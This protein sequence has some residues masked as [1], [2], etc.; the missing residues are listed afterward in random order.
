MY[1]TA[2]GYQLSAVSTPVARAF[3]RAN[4]AGSVLS[5]PKDLRTFPKP[6]RAGFRIKRFK[7]FEALEDLYEQIVCGKMKLDLLLHCKGLYLHVTAMAPRSIACYARG[8]DMW[9]KETFPAYC[10]NKNK[11]LML[12]ATV[13]LM[14][15][16]LRDGW[17][18]T[19]ISTRSENLQ[20][21][22]VYVH[23]HNLPVDNQL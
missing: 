15:R 17:S 9:T 13:F 19:V 5:Q 11:K 2:V 8:L 21:I 1:G 7:C 6:F 4:F 12:V 23:N 10:R 22:H 18:K 20:H 3:S 14:L 16:A